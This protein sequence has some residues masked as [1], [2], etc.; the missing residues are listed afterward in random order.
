MNKNGLKIKY[1]MLFES[2]GFNNYGLLNFKEVF[3][4]QRM[5]KVMALLCAIA[6]V[7]SSVTVSNAVSAAATDLPESGAGV[8]IRVQDFGAGDVLF[9]AGLDTIKGAT[10]YNL[11]VDGQLWGAVSNGQNIDLANFK[12]GDHKF[13]AT[14]IKD[15]EE[16]AKSKDFTV[17]I[18]DNGQVDV[19]DV[20]DGTEILSGLQFADED[21]TTVES[22]DK[23]WFEY[24]GE[25]TNNGDGS[26]S[27]AVP[28]Y[29][30]GDNWATQLKQN[31]VQLI[32]DKWYKATYT[33]K[34][35]VDK[36]IQLMVQQNVNWTVFKT[37]TTAVKAGETKTV[38]VVFQATETTDKVL[39][40]F[41]MGY[42]DNTASEAA[43]VTIS[44][45]SLKVYNADPSV[46]TPTTDETTPAVTDSETTTPVVTDPA[47]TAPE[48]TDLT[49][50]TPVVTDPVTTPVASDITMDQHYTE[51][52]TYTVGGYSVYVGPWMNS[53]AQVGVDPA[54]PNHIKV[55][56]LTSNYTEAWGV[57]VKK[58]LYNLKAG[59]KYTIEWPI[60]AASNDGTVKLTEGAEIK[61]TGGAQ[62]LTS[63]YT[64]KGDGTDEFVVGMGWVNTA[65]PIEFFAPVVKDAEGNV[66]DIAKP[67][68]PETTTP[69]VTDPTETS[70][71]A[72]ETSTE[73][74]ETSTDETTTVAPETSTDETTTVAPA[75]TT[76]EVS[77]Q[78][79]TTTKKPGKKVVLKK[80]KITKA[81]RK[82]VKAKKIKLTFKRV[83]N[84]NKYKVEVSTSKKFK[85]VLVRKTVKK[86]SVTI[87]GKA[88][89]N[90]KKLFVRVRAIGAKKWAV[91]KVKIKK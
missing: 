35:D 54:D 19:P 43:N 81:T 66:V 58:A 83:K 74:P 32:K 46:D 53:T 37:E 90:K 28:A 33:V 71:E 5:R 61:L 80:T 75:T 15:G 88:L 48:V 85:K 12:A 30:S 67:E 4:K 62:T 11:Y 14:G 72:P 79:P 87:K 6:M 42:V 20:V 31:K 84:A 47:T 10:S 34:S 52:G 60:V 50:T 36:S 21:A 69:V 17:T 29:S 9:V 78:A 59:E 56:Q 3:M 68:D 7:I 82:S 1:H 18:P 86:V 51:E 89:K 27:V 25:Y 64:A 8:V 77:T 55:Q 70:T 38:E 57:Q 63:S 26:V 91:K 76:P 41:M 45:V 2:R 40:G 22:E 73:A 49:T 44:G 39:F 13:F 23:P 16:F 24:G 65:N